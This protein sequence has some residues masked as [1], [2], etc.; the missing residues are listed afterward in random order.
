MKILTNILFVV[1]LLI[2]VVLTLFGA[3]ASLENGAS[4]IGTVIGG[5]VFMAFGIT[6]FVLNRN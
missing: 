2:G 5:G 4:G 6:V 1:S 3:M